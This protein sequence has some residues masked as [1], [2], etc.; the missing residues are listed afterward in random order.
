MK[1]GVNL[2]VDFAD[3]VKL[4]K[5]SLRG[6]NSRCF[7][8]RPVAT[9]L[10]F[11]RC[12][13]LKFYSHRMTTF[14][15]SAHSWYAPLRKPLFWWA[16]GLTIA[17]DALGLD[18]W[19]MAAI[20]T[21]QGFPLRNHPF[22]AEVLHTQF[23]NAMLVLYGLAWLMV[24]WPLGP[25]RQFSRGQRW[26]AIVGVSLSLV[27]I[28]SLKRFSATSCPWDWAEFGGLAQPLSHW[29]WGV[30]DGGSGNCF[31]GGHASGALAFLSLAWVGLSAESVA[32]QRWGRRLLWTILGL[33]ALM[34][35]A[36]TLR[37]AHPPS[38]TLWTAWICAAVGWGCVWASHC[39]FV[40]RAVVSARV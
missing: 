36:Q 5:G 37:G 33:G 28:S 20:G 11:R 30:L 15:V 4:D 8:R 22:V 7:D 24:F 12:S 29:A 27:V 23:K 26:A 39:W 25:V 40:R 31:P 19:V 18:R 9:L 21:P 38:H 14:H 6:H 35:V 17:W 2:T 16:L 1:I 34:G 10:H 32:A 13:V 3:E